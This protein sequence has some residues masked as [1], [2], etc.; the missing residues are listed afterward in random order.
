MAMA[1]AEWAANS[2]PIQTLRISR[3]AT[4]GVLPTALDHHPSTDC[5]GH[6]RTPTPPGR[7]LTDAGPRAAQRRAISVGGRLLRW[8]GSTCA[9]AVTG[10]AAAGLVCCAVCS[11]ERD[12]TKLQPACERS[13]SP[14]RTGSLSAARATGLVLKRVHAM[15]ASNAGIGFHE[16]PQFATGAPRP[17][18]GEATR[19]VVVSVLDAANSVGRLPARRTPPPGLAVQRP[20]PPRGRWPP[21]AL[22]AR[23]SRP[24]VRDPFL[25]GLPG[26]LGNGR[27]GKRGSY[28]RLVRAVQ[29]LTPVRAKNS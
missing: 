3:L 22:T 5:R 14:R 10:C 2:N 4:D 21:L 27:E 26:E 7:N 18:A 12:G 1:M 19:P 20:H 15:S 23:V 13:R 29:P 8:R 24:W 25:Q 17:Q 28:L 9:T 11:A 16:R 6:H